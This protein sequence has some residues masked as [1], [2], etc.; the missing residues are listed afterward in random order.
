MARANRKAYQTIM[1]SSA[2][3]TEFL[4]LDPAAV[5]YVVSL[6]AYVSAGAD[7]T[8]T[9]EHTAIPQPTTSSDVLNTPLLT[10][11]SESGSSNFAFPVAAVRLNVTA[12]TTGS[13]TL[14][15]WQAGGTGR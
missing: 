7:L 8:Y 9:V 5:P 4:L 12:H 11:K 15:V 13:V 10:S 14:H 2:G 3:T 6:T 1:A